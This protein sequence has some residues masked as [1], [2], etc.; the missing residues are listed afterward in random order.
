MALERFWFAGGGS[1]FCVRVRIFLAAASESSSLACDDDEEEQKLTTQLP[2]H[3]TGI[4]ECCDA[5]FYAP[6]A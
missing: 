4:G 5:Q 1:K 2:Y 6:C 3:P